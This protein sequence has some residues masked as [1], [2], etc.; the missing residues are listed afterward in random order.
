VRGKHCAAGKETTSLSTGGCRQS[1]PASRDS[2]IAFSL[3]CA[4]QCLM[5]S[6][7]LM[8]C[9]CRTE[10]GMGEATGYSVGAAP[11]PAAPWSGELSL[12]RVQ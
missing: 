5:S 11:H 2:H 4:T 1:W 9:D 6:K 3:F 12:K 7:E 10:M 8:T